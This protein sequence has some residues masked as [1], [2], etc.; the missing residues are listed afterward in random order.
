MDKANVM[1]VHF[2]LPRDA[3]SRGRRLSRAFLTK[4]KKKKSVL[5]KTCRD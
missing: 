4:K 5:K 2:H 1:F 3:F